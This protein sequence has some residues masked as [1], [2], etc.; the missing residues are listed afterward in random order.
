[1]HPVADVLMSAALEN[2]Q[3]KFPLLVSTKEGSMYKY[4]ETV[5]SVKFGQ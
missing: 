1:M 3:K 5:K 4:V 2:D